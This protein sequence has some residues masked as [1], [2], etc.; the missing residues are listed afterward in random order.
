MLDFLLNLYRHEKR[1]ISCSCW[2]KKMYHKKRE[3]ACVYAT[4]QCSVYVRPSTS[5]ITMLLREIIYYYVPLETTWNSLFSPFVAQRT[6]KTTSS[7]NARFA[8]RIVRQ[9]NFTCPFQIDQSQSFE[10]TISS[11]SLF[12][13]RTIFILRA[14]KR[15]R[16]WFL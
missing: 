9:S 8:R 12:L 16:K 6:I 5:F 7:V 2:E 1:L 13:Y 14:R 15:K 4:R 11:P 3:T 10:V